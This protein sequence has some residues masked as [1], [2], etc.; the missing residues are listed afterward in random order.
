MTDNSL[1]SSHL[2]PVYQDRLPIAWEAPEHKPSEADLLHVNNTNEEILKVIYTLDETHVDAEDPHDTLAQHVIRIDAKVNFLMDMVGQLLLK[3]LVIPDVH[4]VALQATQIEWLTAEPPNVSAYIHVHL[5]LKIKYP[6]P[7]VLP[8]TVK[9]IEPHGDTYKVVCE[10]DNPGENV[11]DWL[12][13]LV[14]RQHRRSI[15]LSRNKY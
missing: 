12:E 6:K 15:A 13:K 2:P 5:Y 7:L 10:L 1:E 9:S 3:S 8:A 4:D 14:F 11:Q